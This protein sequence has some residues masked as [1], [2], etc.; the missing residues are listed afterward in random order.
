MLMGGT[1]HDK[2]LQGG[3]S[4]LRNELLNRRQKVQTARLGIEI[5]SHRARSETRRPWRAADE[6]QQG[7]D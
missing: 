3:V 6:Q 7:A 4:I 5:P 2:R 1:V